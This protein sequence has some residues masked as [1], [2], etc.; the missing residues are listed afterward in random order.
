VAERREPTVSSVMSAKEDLADRRARAARQHN[1]GT[2]SR[3]AVQSS[4][5]SGFVWFTFLITLWALAGTGYAIWQLQLAQQASTNQATRILQLEDKLAIS[6][7]SASQSLASVGAKVRQLNVK[8]I[9][10]ESEIAKLWAT[11]NVNRAAIGDTDKKLQSL[12]KGQSKITALERTIL[13]MNK[14]VGEL[15]PL[16]AALSSTSQRVAEQDLLLQSV[17]ERLSNNREMLATHSDTLNLLSAQAGQSQSALKKIN[18]IDKRLQNSEGAITSLDAFRRTV[19]RDLQ[20]L[21]QVKP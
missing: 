8:T 17:R 19:N 9:K 18:S 16:K 5:K 20:K 1:T 6:D 11:R 12:E 15:T 21:K 3:V 2:P 7:D 14:T 4:S 10:A 13:S